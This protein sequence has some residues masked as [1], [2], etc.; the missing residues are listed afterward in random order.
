MV[1]SSFRGHVDNALED[2]NLVSAGF[3][4]YVTTRSATMTED[5]QRDKIRQEEKKV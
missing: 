3:R 4:L 5:G 2:A 1:S